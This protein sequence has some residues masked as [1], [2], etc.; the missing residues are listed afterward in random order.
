MQ[1]KKV[2]LIYFRYED[3]ISPRAFTEELLLRNTNSFSSSVCESV[4]VVLEWEK[5]RDVRG[6]KVKES[7]LI[8]AIRFQGRFVHRLSRRRYTP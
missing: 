1:H 4:P 2:G 8:F 5:E 7:F 3:V 6:W